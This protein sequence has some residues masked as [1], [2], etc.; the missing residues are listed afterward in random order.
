MSRAIVAV[1]ASVGGLVVGAIGGRKTSKVTIK[2]VKSYPG[3]VGKSLSGTAKK[4]GGKMVFWKKS[5]KKKAAPKKT[6][7]GNKTAK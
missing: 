6:N 1:I 7:G 4:I 5:A 2:D 3:K